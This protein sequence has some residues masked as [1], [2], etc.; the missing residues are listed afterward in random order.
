MTQQLMTA[1]YELFGP[2]VES[3]WF[4]LASYGFLLNPVV[5]V[6][7]LRRVITASDL[8][9]ISVLTFWGFALLQ[10]LTFFVAIAAKNFPL[11]ISIIFSLII[12]FSIIAVTLWRQGR[13]AAGPSS[14]T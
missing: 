4:A 1:M 7:Q 12:T 11:F 3:S 6:P 9:G 5:L 8:S 13:L 2:V 10:A 14:S